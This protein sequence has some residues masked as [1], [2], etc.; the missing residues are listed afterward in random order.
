MKTIWKYPLIVTDSQ[1]VRMP[2]GASVLSAADQYGELCIWAFV[3]SDQPTEERRVQIVG[4]GNP[5]DLTG[6]W[7]FVGSV[8]QSVFVWHVFVERT[9]V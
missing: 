7:Q 6:E 8:Q 1:I 5:V 3:D 4:T 9:D 2:Q